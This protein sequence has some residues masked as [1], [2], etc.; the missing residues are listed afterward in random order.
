MVVLFELPVSILSEMIWFYE[1]FGGRQIKRQQMGRKAKLAL[2]V[3]NLFNNFELVNSSVQKELS[4]FFQDC[5]G[6]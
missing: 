4:F 3:F 1:L 2:I 5:T 6:Y